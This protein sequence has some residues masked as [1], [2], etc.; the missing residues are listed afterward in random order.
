[1]ELKQFKLGIK[2]LEEAF[3]KHK[4]WDEYD[5]VGNWWGY[6]IGWEHTDYAT[7]SD[8]S[9]Y[10]HWSPAQMY[11]ILT[12]G[13]SYDIATEHQ[14]WVI[15]NDGE[16]DEW[17]VNLHRYWSL[18]MDNKELTAEEFQRKLKREYH[19]DRAD[20]LAPEYIKKAAEEMRI[21]WEKAKEEFSKYSK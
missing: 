7:F 10:Y 11:E 12:R 9:D 1:M 21:N 17:W 20:R 13:I 6:W 16:R 19:L 8:G 18:R 14:D 5:I 2:E 3:M 4:D 15:D